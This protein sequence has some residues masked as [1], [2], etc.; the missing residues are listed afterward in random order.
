M[1]DW[2]KFKKQTHFKIHIA[3]SVKSENVSKLAASF[4]GK[5]K[6]SFFKTFSFV[7]DAQLLHSAETVAYEVFWQVAILFPKNVTAKMHTGVCS[8]VSP[9]CYEV[10]NRS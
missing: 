1:P 3:H 5:I 7:F 8:Y 2:G 6:L 10:F 9:A 4:F